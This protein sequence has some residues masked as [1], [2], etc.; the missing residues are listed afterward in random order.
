MPW[1]DNANPGPWGSPPGH[2]EGKPDNE[3]GRRPEPPRRP[4]PPPGG[5]DLRKL[6]RRLTEATRRWLGRAA[7]RGVPPRLLAAAAAVVA[8]AWTLTG[9][10][11]VQAN[12]QAVITRFGGFARSEGP[13]LHYHLPIPFERAEFVSVANQN[14]T[15]IGGT[16]GAEA[17]DESLMLTGDEDIVDLSFTVQWHVSDAAAYL[18]LIKD[19]DDAVK[20]VAE[21][22]MREIVGRTALKSILTDGRGAVQDQSLALMQRVLDRYRSGITLDAVQIQN[23]SPP[24]EAAAA[25]QDIAKAGQEAQSASNDADTYRDKVVA[26]AHGDAAKIVQAAQGYREQV[27][28]YAQGQASAFDQLYPQYRRAP[29]ITRER[30]YLEMMERVLGHSRKV[31]IDGRGA[32]APIILP[33]DL[34]K[35]N[36]AVQVSPP[37]PAPAAGQ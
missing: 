18:F 22:A 37:S 17:P 25:Y 28:R 29:G 1:N 9:L 6:Q 14:K 21:S 27:V 15:V 34:F 10:Y 8:V 36:A 31:I 4:A 12:Q 33:P 2:D 32:A 7:S 19:P 24:A 35:G 16:S 20:A 13:G 5:P 23:A 30:L 11:E 3:P 26:E